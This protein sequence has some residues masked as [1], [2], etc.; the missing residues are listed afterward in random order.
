MFVNSKGSVGGVAFAFAIVYVVWGSTYLAIRIGVHDAPAI[1]FAGTRFLLATGPMLAYAYWRGARLPKARRDWAV[2]AITSLLMLV[3][4]NG[5]VTWSEQWVPS[6]QAALLVATSAL[7]MAGF[8]TLGLSGEAL[9]RW[10][11]AGL[12]VGFLGVA[13]LVGD[14]LRA[15]LAPWPAYLAL[16]ISPIFWA[17]GSVVS[18]RHPVGC[19]PPMAAALQMAIAGIVQTGLGLSLGETAQWHW[20]SGT[21][22]A[23]IYL[24]LLGSCLAY[25]AYFWLVHEVTPSQLGTYAYVNPAVAVLL[26]WLVLDERLSEMQIGGTL[27]IL[28]SVI[29]VSLASRQPRS[30]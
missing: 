7:W 5:L 21:V 3:G 14:G 15:A 2:I 10:T 8:G 24:A 11:L 20:T 29:G 22:G 1:L 16:V 30:A 13:V 9:S 28:L 27:I 4:A 6:N 18:R 25:G 26:G 12:I 19:P 23:L 17:A